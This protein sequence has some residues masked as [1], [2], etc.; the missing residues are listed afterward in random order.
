[1]PRK[2]YTFEVTKIEFKWI[3]ESLRDASNHYEDNSYDALADELTIIKGE[4]SNG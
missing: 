3:I 2:L 1:M 4:Q